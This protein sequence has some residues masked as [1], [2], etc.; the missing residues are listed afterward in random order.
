MIVFGLNSKLNGERTC[1]LSLG[2]LGLEEM[3]LVDNRENRIT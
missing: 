3:S 1:N 2:S